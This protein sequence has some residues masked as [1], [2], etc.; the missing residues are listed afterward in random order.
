MTTYHFSHKIFAVLK[1]R[2]ANVL[3]A[4][5]ILSLVCNGQVPFDTL[6]AR[7]KERLYANDYPRAMELYGDCLKEAQRLHDGLKIGNSY[8]GIGIC[9]D[10]SSDFENA[11]TY[12]FKALPAYESVGNIKK[13]AGTLKNIGNTYRT[14]KSFEK[15]ADFFEQAFLKY[16]QAKDSTG[17]SSVSN[18]LGLL[19]MDQKKTD[20][21]II[22]FNRVI[23]IYK[24]YAIKEVNGFALNNLG[25][26]YADKNDFKTSF[27]Y[28]SA[29]LNAMQ[30]M[31]ND[32]GV[33]LVLNNTGNLLIRQKKFNESLDYSLRGLETA[34]KI[35]SKEI[36][37]NSYENLGAA[38]RE[39]QDYKKSN[40][41]FG[42]LIALRDTIFREE[43]AKSYAEMES[44]YQN[45]KKKKEIIV[46]KKDNA[47]K[48]LDLTN[49]RRT[50]TFLLVTLLLIAA[51]AALI[52]RSYAAKQKLNMALN[53]AN[54]K[55]NEANQSKT[56]LLGI[57]THDL[58]TPVSSLFNFLQLQKS[59]PGRLSAEQQERFNNQ[60]NASAEN[61][62][63]TME[64]VLVWSKSQMEKFE[65]VIEPVDVDEF[66]DEILNLNKTA[67]GNKNIQLVK[68]CP[69]NLY[70]NTDPNFL[71]II[72]RNLMSNAVK[73]TPSN[74]AI[75]LSANKIADGVTISVKDN[76]EGMSP[77]HV[78]NIFNWNSIRSD[79]SGLGLR[80]AKEFTEK[81]NGSISVAS[82]VGDGT[83]FTLLFPANRANS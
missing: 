71:K 43:S 16:N 13:Q 35:Q 34:K 7:A 83:T 17:L 68:V 29:S 5:L 1:I 54:D 44:R 63:I 74:G 72:L 58:R 80:L 41:Y 38:Y 18:D 33:A 46:L 32:Y 78:A 49:Q 2:K 9:Y 56:K 42:E 37:A 23:S 50:R 76:G 48:D 73:F 47:I 21:A 19:Y 6:I 11:L 39:L 8:I 45:E 15:A 28:Y 40:G 67:A 52:Y 81:L 75:H 26:A 70:L 24:K 66:F 14:I 61:V 79:S 57:I 10:K 31:N 55:L 82:V 27:E 64:D 53:I 30:K 59:A 51:I 62:L 69:T 12:Y 25:L 77:E 65:P 4:F 20:S 22:F 60:I 36:I 3:F